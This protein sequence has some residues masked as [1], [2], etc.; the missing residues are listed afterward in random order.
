VK[1]NLYQVDTVTN[2]DFGGNQACVVPLDNWLSD[3][4]L[5]KITKENTVAETAFF[6]GK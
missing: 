4:I 2:T 5:L 6:V 1:Y 3:E